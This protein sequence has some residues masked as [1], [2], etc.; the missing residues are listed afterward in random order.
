MAT[1]LSYPYAKLGHVTVAEI[2][3]HSRPVLVVD[4]KRT[5]GSVKQTLRLRF[6]ING[7]IKYILIDIYIYI[8]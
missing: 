7:E 5:H 1:H 2:V 6:Y 8:M 3:K 4:K